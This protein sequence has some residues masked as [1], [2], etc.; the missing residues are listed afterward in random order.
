MMVIDDLLGAS[1]TRASPSG[2]TVGGT[3]FIDVQTGNAAI[4][5]QSR[6][7]LRVMPAEVVLPVLVPVLA[8]VAAGF[9]SSWIRWWLRWGRWT[10]HIDNAGE[11]YGTFTGIS[12][13]V[14]AVVVTVML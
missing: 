2:L 7:M 4:S 11:P 9:G 5:V 1:V 3:I 6:L 10:G 14:V 12:W 13:E 8:A